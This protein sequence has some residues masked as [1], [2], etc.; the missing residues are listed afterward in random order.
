MG[1]GKSSGACVPHTGAPAYV[2]SGL[3]IWVTGVSNGVIQ[4]KTTG[5]LTEESEEDQEV[6]RRADKQASSN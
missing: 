4:T 5:P 6:R 2:S 3:Q 1:K